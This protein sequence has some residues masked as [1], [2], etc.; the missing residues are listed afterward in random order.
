MIQQI[1]NNGN[2]CEKQSSKYE[3]D[4][5][6]MDSLK[7]WVYICKKIEIKLMII[8]LIYLFYIKP[9]LGVLCR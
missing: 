9:V 8:F 7:I 3:I 4:V 2:I 1:T 5:F 6:E